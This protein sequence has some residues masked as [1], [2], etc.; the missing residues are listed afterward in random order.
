MAQDK[1]EK[2][3]LK[4]KLASISCRGH[5]ILPSFGDGMGRKLP[6]FC[7]RHSFATA[8]IFFFSH[9]VTKYSQSKLEYLSIITGCEL[10]SLSHPITVDWETP[11]L[12]LCLR[13]EEELFMK[14][15]KFGNSRVIFPI[16]PS[17]AFVDCA[18][19]IS[20]K[21][22]RPG[23]FSTFLSWNEETHQAGP[24]LFHLPG[25]E[26]SKLFLNFTEY[27]IICELGRKKKIP[28]PLQL[29]HDSSSDLG[30]FFGL[31]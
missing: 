26:I 21:W 1:W 7:L 22:G 6:L 25:L 15:F 17:L 28:G 31:F 18:G 12:N 2:H 24:S 9:I 14:K 4:V 8:C 16:K 30:K 11:Y 20:D 19:I 29:F 13:R 10:F 23:S 27:Q 5:S 3:S